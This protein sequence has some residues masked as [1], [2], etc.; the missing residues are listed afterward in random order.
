[1]PA[2]G[3]GGGAVH[4]DIGALGPVLVPP[5]GHGMHTRFVMALPGVET[6]SFAMQVVMVAHITSPVIE[7]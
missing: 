4:A 3:G 1:M 2:S 6:Y 5:P 7:L